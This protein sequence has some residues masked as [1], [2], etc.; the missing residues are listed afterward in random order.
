MDS[1]VA[2][3]L[4]NSTFYVKD[5]E[6]QE[7]DNDSNPSIRQLHQAG[8]SS[9]N[10]LFFDDICRRDRT[11]DV[12]AFYTEELICTHREFSL[13]VRKAMSAKVE[14]CFGKRV[15]ERMKA[16]LELVSLKLWGEYEG[17]ELFLEIENRTAV[18][19]ILFVYHP[20]FFFYHGQTS[21]TALRFRKK[22]G[23][24]QDLHLSVAGKLGGIEITPN[25]YESKHLPHHYGQ[26]DNASNHVV[27][28]LEKEADDQLRAAFPEQYK[29]I[30]AGA[31]A[32]AEKV[33]I[34]GQQTLCQLS[35]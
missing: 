34:E 18:R 3:H 24:N 5:P 20:Q 13:S 25:F 32:L 12:E 15:F 33:K 11:K 23:R 10:C 16:Y 35:G 8:F 29:K 9:K 30:E 1:T 17:V 21:E 22:F 27:K 14:V 6:S 7:T 2:C 26:F 4:H 19:F 31:R 28:R